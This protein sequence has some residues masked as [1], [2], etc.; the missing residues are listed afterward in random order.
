MN[1]TF[2]AKGQYWNNGLYI[3]QYYS[4]IKYLTKFYWF[5]DTLRQWDICGSYAK[6]D[7]SLR[8][9]TNES[10]EFTLVKFS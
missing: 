1:D 5:P 10:L 7:S 8:Q 6:G 3:L 4:L 9:E 2:M